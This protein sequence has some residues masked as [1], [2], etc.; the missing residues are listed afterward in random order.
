MRANGL[1]PFLLVVRYA[2]NLKVVSSSLGNP[3]NNI[4]LLNGKL[5]SRSSIFLKVI[6]LQDQ[7]GS[8][9]CPA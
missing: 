7:T 1:V 9:R 4:S 2:Y 3:V 5:I 8:C 6:L